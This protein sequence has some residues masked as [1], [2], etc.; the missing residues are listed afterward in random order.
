[1]KLFVFQILSRC[2][3]VLSTP[4]VVRSLVKCGVDTDRHR[5]RHCFLTTHPAYN[6]PCV[7]NV[8]SALVFLVNYSYTLITT[9]ALSRI[10]QN[11]RHSTV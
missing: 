5:H 7:S 11:P 2:F 9:R 8:Y 1:M 4:L 6:P 3:Q 10:N